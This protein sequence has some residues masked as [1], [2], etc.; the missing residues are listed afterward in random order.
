MKS[1]I[2]NVNSFNKKGNDEAGG[3]SLFFS[4]THHTGITLSFKELT[5]FGLLPTAHYNAI[6]KN[7][8]GKKG[9]QAG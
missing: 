3:T 7:G 1:L 4:T 9:K 8:C 5:S 2:H 6:G